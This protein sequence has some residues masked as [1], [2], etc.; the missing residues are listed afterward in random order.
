MNDDDES[1]PVSRTLKWSVCEVDWRTFELKRD[2][3]IFPFHFD[4]RFVFERW[5]ACYELEHSS[6]SHARERKCWKNAQGD[7]LYQYEG[8][9]LEYLEFIVTMR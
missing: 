7:N 8:Y 6:T 4:Y 1:E 3:N 5:C 2:K 9:Q